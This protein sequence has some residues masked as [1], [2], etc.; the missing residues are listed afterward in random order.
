MLERIGARAFVAILVLVTYAIVSRT[1]G[2]RFPFSTF[3]MYAESTRGRPSRIVARDEQGIAELRD[4]D[5]WACDELPAFADAV[6]PPEQPSSTI[7]YV[8]R[9]AEAWVRA[10]GGD[11]P[12]ARDVAIVRHVWVFGPTDGAPRTFDCAIARCRAVR[13]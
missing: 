3:S 7:P 12:S 2:D 10:H 6:C 4:F 9:E 5:H 1:V 8:D 13:R 11:D